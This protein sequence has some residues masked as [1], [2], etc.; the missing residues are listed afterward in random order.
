MKLPSYCKV[1][2]L[3]KMKYIP[4]WHLWVMYENIASCLKLMRTHSCDHKADSLFDHCLCTSTNNC[5][6]CTMYSGHPDNV[7]Q[8]KKFKCKTYFYCHCS[9][10]KHSNTNC[11]V[12]NMSQIQ[13][14]FVLMSWCQ[15][16]HCSQ[17]RQ[18]W[19]CC[20]YN[21]LASVGRCNCT[22]PGRCG[23]SGQKPQASPG[24]GCCRRAGGASCSRSPAGAG[25]AQHWSAQWSVWPWHYWD[26]GAPLQNTGSLLD[27][28]QDTDPPGTSVKLE[29]TK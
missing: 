22:S 21:R 16:C 29:H 9:Q 15:V 17:F 25:S 10:F 26:H 7:L 23:P 4:N 5:Y 24:L 27:Q 19:A 13:S 8:L 12:P 1:F 14:G 11:N 20:P 6:W 2:W 18:W 28:E 3:I